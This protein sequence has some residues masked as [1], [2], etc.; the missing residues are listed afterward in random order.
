M[1]DD[2]ITGKSVSVGQ[3]I[4]LRFCQEDKVAIYKAVCKIPAS[5]DRDADRHEVV[6]FDVRAERTHCNSLRHGTDVAGS[7]ALRHRT[8]WCH[9]PAARFSPKGRVLGLRSLAV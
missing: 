7:P 1:G 3:L 9:V 4:S 2:D 8:T 5:D 6:G